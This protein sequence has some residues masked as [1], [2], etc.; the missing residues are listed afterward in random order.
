MSDF[1][2]NAAAAE[3][4][5]Q[6]EAPV[7]PPAKSEQPS[8]PH[9]VVKAW[10]EWDQKTREA[11]V[12]AARPPEPH[13]VV[14]AFAQWDQPSEPA[15]HPSSPAEKDRAAAAPPRV[16]GLLTPGNIDLN[17]RPVVKNPDG[18]ISSVRSMS[19]NEG[20]KEI[21]IPT[22]HDEGRIMANEEAIENY[23]KTGKH[24]G[25][26]DTPENATAYAQQ[27]HEEQARKY[28]PQPATEAEVM[29][30]APEAAYVKEPLT[31]EI[32]AAG[33]FAAGVNKP[34]LE[35]LHGAA[36]MTEEGLALP[37]RVVSG[38]WESRTP[39]TISKLTGA[40]KEM[41]AP[42][43]LVKDRGAVSRFV[44]DLAG[45]LAAYMLP[46][47]ATRAFGYTLPMATTLQKFGSNLFTFAA[48]D[49]AQAIGAGGGGEQA[50]NALLKSIPT[51]ALFTVA[52]AIP[53]NKLVKSPWVAKALESAATGTAFA[54][55]AAIG[56]ER[57][58]EALAVSFLTGAS[59]HL[60]TSGLPQRKMTATEHN[61][62]VQEWRYQNQITDQEW[63]QVQDLLKKTETGKAE[64][65]PEEIMSLFK[66][67][68]PER[69]TPEARREAIFGGP[70]GQTIEGQ[71]NR[72][73]AVRAL[74]PQIGDHAR[75]ER[76]YD[77]YRAGDTD[78]ALKEFPEFSAWATE[79][80]KRAAPSPL[81]P[82]GYAAM[83]KPQPVP[84]A[85]V[86]PAPGSPPLPSATALEPTRPEAPMG[87]PGTMAQETATKPMESIAASEATPALTQ[88]EELKADFTQPSTAPTEEAGRSPTGRKKPTY[89]IDKAIERYDRATIVKDF[90]KFNSRADILKNFTLEERK[91]LFPFM[92]REAQG[93]DELLQELKGSFPD[94][95]GEFETDAHFLRAII[96]GQLKPRDYNRLGEHYDDYIAEQAARE[97]LD[98]D[99]LAQAEADVERE[100]GIERRAIE[101]AQYTG[102]AEDWWERYLPDGA[103]DATGEGITEG[104][105]PPLKTPKHRLAEA[106]FGLK[107]QERPES[108][109]DRRLQE[110][111]TA[112]PDVDPEKAGQILRSQ[113]D[114]PHHDV[115]LLSRLSPE[116]INQVAR[117]NLSATER[118]QL[119]RK[120]TD[121]G[122]QQSLLGLGKGGLFERVA[123]TPAV[124]QARESLAKER[125]VAP[126]K[127]S[128]IGDMEGLDGTPQL[129]M[130][131]L[132]DQGHPQD[133]STWSWPVAK[134]EASKISTETIQKA[135]GP[136]AQV[137][138]STLIP[139]VHEVLLPNGRRILVRQNVDIQVAPE[140]LAAYGKKELGPG[141]YVSGEWRT[142]DRGGLISLAKGEGA[143]ALRHESFH[144]AMEMVLTAKERQAVLDKYG[145]EEAAARAYEDWQPQEDP[146]T[147][148]QKILDFFRRIVETFRPSAEGTFGKI[149]RGEVWE[150]EEG[151]PESPGGKY[152]LA[153]PEERQWDIIGGIKGRLE[154]NRDAAQAHYAGVKDTL[155]KLFWPSR[156]TEEGRWTHEKIA[157]RQAEAEAEI[158]RMNRNFR[159]FDQDTN[160]TEPR[161]LEFCRLYESGQADQVTDPTFKAFADTYRSEEKRQMKTIHELGVDVNDLDNYLDHLWEPSE[162]L[163]QLKQALYSERSGSIQGPQYFHNLR[164][165]SC[166]PA[167]IEADL[168]PRYPT[169]AQTVMAGRAAH[170]KFIGAQRA[171][172][173]VKDADRLKVVKSLEDMPEG[174]KKFPGS[175]G[176]VW[177]RQ[178]R[179]GGFMIPEEALEGALPLGETGYREVPALKGWMRA[180]YRVGPEEV[181]RQFEN[182][183]GRGL[184]GNDAFQLYQ[185]TLHGVRHLQMALSAWHFTF[186]GINAM[187]S[188]SWSGLAD[189][190]GGLFT[191][192]VRRLGAGL[193][194]LATAPLALP[195]Y[196]RQ[197][198]KFD[199]ALMDPKHADPNVVEIANILVGGGTRLAPET[200][201]KKMLGQHLQETV[202]S[203]KGVHPLQSLG[204][205]LKTASSPLMDWVVPQGKN[206]QIW[207]EYLQEAERFKRQNGR[208]P[209]QEEARRL[210]YEVR[211]HAD[212]VWGAVARDNQAMAPVVR[213]LF[214]AW[215]QFPRF[216]IGSAKLLSRDISGAKGILK[217]AVRFARGEPVEN[218]KIEDRLALQYSAGLMFSVGL[219][220]GLMHWA[221]TGNPPK[222]LKDYYFPATGE[223]L[224]NGAEERLQLPSYL[225]D[226]MGLY[227]H[228][229]R[230][231]TAKESTFLHILNDLIENKEFW[232]NQIID[233]YAPLQEQ[234][235]GLLKY[236]GKQMSPFVVQ[237]FEQGA[238]Q[239]PLRGGLSF[240]GIRQT[241][242]EYSNS[243]AQNI[244]DE[245]SRLTWTTTSKE[246]AE[247]KRLKA[248]LLKLAREQNQVGFEETVAEA[249]SEGKIT[250]QQVKEI[251]KESQEPPGLSRFTKLPLEW[252]LRA[253]G[254]ASDYEKDQWQPYF[255]KKIMREKPETLI[256]LREPVAAALEE[257]GLSAAA[258][259]VSDLTIPEG[260]DRM[261]LSALGMPGPSRQM[262]GLENLDA[263]LTLAFEENL[264]KL[265]NQSKKKD[266][267]K[268]TFAVLGF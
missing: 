92:R 128:Y 138:A 237:T 265:T 204:N 43:A 235:L 256:R 177:A 78:T 185:N 234:G 196:M 86:S 1:G 244:I 171:L 223:T 255:L 89:D 71:P 180:G 60:V 119:F 116:E 120:A 123:E 242:R 3:F 104:Q 268:S 264:A 70:L 124:A 112:Y 54:G 122:Q 174:W 146:H 155:S 169:L 57:D 37:Y 156:R 162:K 266:R 189:T 179:P 215:L 76:F 232:G 218:L 212:N 154:G 126:E 151:K 158:V 217:N 98:Q 205:I 148:F 183:A 240:L 84:G 168:K 127:L 193:G 80:Q 13:P 142:I 30:G 236:A 101:D 61:K 17:N 46:G 24:L 131:N 88:P 68:Q 4:D 59:L 52:Q 262:A 263:A 247:K 109:F 144:G 153:S 238:Q 194:K 31:E 226:A 157:G 100:V 140:A 197:G 51:A 111:T 135:F 251:V 9:P 184:E 44:G 62:F 5:K 115:A 160:F 36:R 19:F 149:K 186:E 85:A 118:E 91:K 75:A 200:S 20:G 125:G 74:V 67:P 47:A 79:Q 198:L 82:G 64:A 224:P 73:D 192:D 34:A 222:Q 201:L 209:N 93:P 130:F 181:V 163:T 114:L 202:E 6:A 97:G 206:G 152:R 253:W 208:E 2:W 214:S 132:E 188:R 16:Q 117:G 216:N 94:M 227:H 49:V 15:A 48:T 254:V 21:L 231:I 145:S 11:A 33:R 248:D 69:D 136:K 134:A 259:A 187:A 173:D 225:K 96:D 150:R 249:I 25:V 108:R 77:L 190:V 250:R 260:V 42:E 133:K 221:F 159:Q 27:L 230:T 81:V 58:P 8:K 257:M 233:P 55:G 113:P 53:F 87:V 83:E 137:T 38:D 261:D 167:G 103:A 213:S 141:E 172:K 56:G 178:E 107:P 139:G 229:V 191:G 14:S 32:K 121:L 12:P 147:L 143:E 239:T 23:R 164:T 243:P 211:E 28:A 165:V 45:G 18:S 207:H 10:E 228:P 203:A 195:I 175:Y 182:Y 241:P 170:E 39:E 22:V 99:T 26:F 106:A 66:T 129:H 110:V 102:P 245:Y 246:A 63:G 50:R 95:F 166:I 105:R 219:V 41:G 72:A 267:R 220:G 90:G 29:R 65:S 7:V 258:A 161:T 176:E 252:A 35:A 210:A 40:L 199:K